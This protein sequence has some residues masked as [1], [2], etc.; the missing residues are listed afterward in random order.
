MTAP[1][2]GREVERMRAQGT[3]VNVFIYTGPDA[4]RRASAK[5]PGCR[6]AV[7]PDLDWRSADF[8]CVR[9]LNLVVVARGWEQDEL[10]RFG[11]HLLQQGAQLVVGLLVIA[12]DRGERVNTTFY[13]RS[14]PAAR[15]A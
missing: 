13:R 7:P 6:L 8:S 1:P 14:R 12:A 10:D 4:W 3:R 15:F 9:G 11:P 5:P 2:Y